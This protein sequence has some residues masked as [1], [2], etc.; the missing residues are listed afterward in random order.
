MQV[1]FNKSTYCTRARKF[2]KYNNLAWCNYEKYMTN[3]KIDT[4]MTYELF[5][6]FKVVF[7][8]DEVSI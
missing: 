3:F 7:S 5:Q 1:V 8:I 4:L 2:S 6:C